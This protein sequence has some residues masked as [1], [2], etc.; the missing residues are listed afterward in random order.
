MPQAP[1]RSDRPDRDP[2]AGV[3]RLIA[4]A[5]EGQTGIGKPLSR[6]QRQTRRSLEAYLKAGLRPRWMERLAEIDHSVAAQRRRIGRAYRRLEE[7]CGG[8]PAQF[9]QR[10]REQASRWR[11]D[12]LNELIEQHNEWYPIER[13]LPMDPRTGDYV[14]LA[15]RSYRRSP[16]GP[17]W[18]LEQFPPTPRG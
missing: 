9:A 13:E 18:V 3:E 10:W 7:E 11:F 17:V 1:G 6:C 12:E 4:R 15:G 2:R 5:A 16:L 8:D 14:R